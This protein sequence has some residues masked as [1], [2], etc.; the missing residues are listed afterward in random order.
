MF[1]HAHL[2]PKEKW[3]AIRARIR[4]DA[5]I[6]WTYAAGMLD[7]EYNPAN[8]KAVTGFKT[9]DCPHRMQHREVYKHVYWHSTRPMPQDYPL[10]EILPE[11]GQEVLQTSPDNHIITARVPRDEGANILAVDITLRTPILHQLMQDAGVNFRAPIHCTV[12]ADDKLIGF[13]PRYDAQFSHKF[14]GQ[15][16]NVITGEIVS[17]NRQLSIREKKFEIFEKLD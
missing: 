8:Q 13:F 5:H 2:L 3:E 4:P 12:L 7:P 16:R 11:A 17:G 9:Q 15:W 10:L 14:D 1:A 6:L